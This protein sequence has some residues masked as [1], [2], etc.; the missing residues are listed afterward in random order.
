MEGEKQKIIARICY[1]ELVYGRIN[2]KLSANFS[3]KKIESLLKQTL[4]NTDEKFFKQRGKNYYVQ[5]ATHE[6]SITINSNTYRVITV[7]KINN[8]LKK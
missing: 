3:R 1:T 7:D 8:P 6:I 5:N 2:K 4:T